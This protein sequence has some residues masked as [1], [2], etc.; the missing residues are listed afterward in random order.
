MVQLAINDD[1]LRYQK[2]LLV[3]TAGKMTQTPEEIVAEKLKQAK[4]AIIETLLEA[5]EGVSLA[6]LPMKLKSF[7]PFP[8]DLNELGFAKLKDLL[9]TI[10]C[11]KMEQRGSNHP[12][13]V[14]IG[15]SANT[16]ASDALLSFTASVII[17]AEDLQ[18]AQP[19][20]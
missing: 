13:A 6:Q 3:W 12:F 7:L 20:P 9:T 8:L 1:L 10:P 17:E 4:D 11:I 18:M 16:S 2:T 5:Q 14:Y 15:H 19:W